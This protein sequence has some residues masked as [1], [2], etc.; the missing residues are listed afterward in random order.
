M[1]GCEGKIGCRGA[2]KASGEAARLALEPGDASMKHR[3]R[4]FVGGYS[5]DA[6]KKC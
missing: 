6:V 2:M 1:V 5:C 4:S 3:G